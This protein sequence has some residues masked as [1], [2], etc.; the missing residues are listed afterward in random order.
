MSYQ[1]SI[2]QAAG[3]KCLTCGDTFSFL[4]VQDA[5]KLFERAAKALSRGT[6][7]LDRL[8]VNNWARGIAGAAR[9]AEYIGALED[10]EFDM[11]QWC[12]N[13]GCI[14]FVEKVTDEHWEA[15]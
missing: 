9:M 4:L 12:A 6:D 3:H 5:N 10:A 8:R 7:N 11:L 15:P 14:E 13:G 2:C 1:H